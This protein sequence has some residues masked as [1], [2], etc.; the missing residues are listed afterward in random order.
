M[1]SFRWPPVSE[2]LY[3]CCPTFP[4]GCIALSYWTRFYSCVFSYPICESNHLCGH[5]HHTCI[6][7]P[8]RALVQAAHFAL[9][10]SACTFCGSLSSLHHTCPHA[11]MHLLTLRQ[12]F[13]SAPRLPNSR[14]QVNIQL[15]QYMEKF[16]MGHFGFLCSLANQNHCFAPHMPP[17]FAVLV[18]PGQGQGGTGDTCSRR[19]VGQAGRVCGWQ[20][21]CCSGTGGG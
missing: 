20:C 8:T 14:D 5:S 13:L 17:C 2:S 9:H 6:R 10:T 12:P 3:F 1:V 11:V 19:E 18:Q 7:N 4:L 21:V 16:G 15:G